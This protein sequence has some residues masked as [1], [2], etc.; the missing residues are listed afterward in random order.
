M[1]CVNVYQK[2]SPAKDTKQPNKLDVIDS[3]CQPASPWLSLCLPIRLINEVDK[4]AEKVVL[5][6][7]VLIKVDL[8][9]AVE[10][11]TFQ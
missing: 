1:L 3:R 2:A 6:G 7:L 11:L 8:T 4:M 9:S 5:H 10:Y